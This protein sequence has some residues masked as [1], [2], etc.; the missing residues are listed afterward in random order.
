MEKNCNTCFFKE[1]DYKGNI[2]TVAPC[3][4]CTVYDK[5][6]SDSV[7][8]WKENTLDEYSSREDIMKELDSAVAAANPLSV[9][10]GGQ[11]YKKLRIQPVEYI[12]ANNLPYIEGNIVKYITRWRDKGGKTDLE[13]VKHYVDLLIQLENP[14]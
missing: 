11:H 12:H 9:Q 7:Y 3:R 6:V 14:K 10:A 5:W 4:T 1:L 13:K 8:F 2:S